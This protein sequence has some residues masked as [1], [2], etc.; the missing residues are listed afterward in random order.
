MRR[1]WGRSAGWPSTRCCPPG[2]ASS[3]GSRSIPLRR[4]ERRALG[5]RRA[6]A[7]APNSSSDLATL[8]ARFPDAPLINVIDGGDIRVLLPRE[9]GD[10]KEASAELMFFGN[11]AYAPHADAALHLIRDIMP[12][13][14]RGR[15]D[16]RAGDR[17]A[18]ATRADHGDAGRPASGRDRLRARRAAPPRARHRGRQPIALRH[19]HE[20]QAPGRARDGPRDGREPDHLRGVR[21]TRRT[22]Y[23]PWW[24]TG[25]RT[26]R[27]P[28]SRCW[29]IR[30]GA[31]RSARRGES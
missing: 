24:P 23:T 17:R 8:R 5:P 10:V 15:P 4:F 30:P 25:R 26:P 2:N 22:G 13:V 18:R 20:E 11:L 31:A 27:A 3:C 21:P 19:G 12:L 14:C 9:A 29:T 16:A 7:L 28:C 6:V 1:C